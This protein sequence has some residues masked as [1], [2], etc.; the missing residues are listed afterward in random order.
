MSIRRFFTNVAVLGMVTLPLALTSSTLVSAYDPL[1][2]ACKNAPDSAVCQT[3]TTAANPISDTITKAANVI[4]LVAGITAVIIII[5]AGLSLILSS[6]D[7]AKAKTARSAIIYALVGLVVIVF[8]RLIVAL[9][10]NQT[11]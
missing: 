7:A 1:S 9:T 5:I 4:A 8:A 3:N 6:G 2:E 10:I 11:S